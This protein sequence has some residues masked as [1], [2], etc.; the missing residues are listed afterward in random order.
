MERLHLVNNDNKF[1]YREAYGKYLARKRLVILALILLLIGVS[2]VSITAGSAGLTLKEVF[3]TLMGEGTAQAKAIIWNV[4][5]PRILTSIVVGGALALTGCVMQSVLRNPLASASTL[6]ISQG[7]SFGATIAI[8]FFSAGIQHNA[9]GSGAISITNPYLV[10]LC[11]F[12]GGIISV[13]VILVLSRIKTITPASMV[14]AGVALSSLFAG[15]TTLVQYFAD[16]VVLAAVVYWTFGD[17]G[18][19]SWNEI[20]LITI[21]LGLGFVYFMLKS[22][23]YNGMQSGLQTARSLGINVDQLILVSMV[24]AALLAATATSFVG[25]INF[26]G[27]VAPHMVRRFVGSDYRYLLPASMLAG[28]CILLLSDLCSRTIVAPIVLPIGAITSFLGA[29]LFLYLIYK[30]AK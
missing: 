20:L 22:W 11:A 25:I 27:L 30:G 14:L 15:G 16:D 23:S 12:L 9:T 10:T 4:R 29:P 18:R 8:V 13:F 3:R 24:L 28:A 26:V 17:L 5:L 19:T 6:G 7:A 1:H 2:L 21:V